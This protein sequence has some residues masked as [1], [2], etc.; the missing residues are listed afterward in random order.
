MK[1]EKNVAIDR[2][3]FKQ[4]QQIFP[5][6][7][8]DFKYWYLVLATSAHINSIQVVIMYVYYDMDGKLLYENL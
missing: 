3:C 5:Y 8:Y 2:N 1:E 6:L 4:Y 7:N